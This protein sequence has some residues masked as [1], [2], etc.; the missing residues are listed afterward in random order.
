TGALSASLV[1]DP[2]AGGGAIAV[3]ANVNEVL[4]NVANRALGRP[5]GAYAPVHPAGS[6]GASQSTADVVHTAA[7]LAVL[8]EAD[9]L[10]AAVARLAAALAE[11]GERFGAAP[12]LARTCL[13]DGLAVEARL[14]VDGAAAAVARRRAT[15][16]RSLSPLHAVVLG[17]TVVGDGTGAPPA[18]RAAVVDLLAERCARPLVAAEVPASSLQHGDDLVEVASALAQL[19]IVVAKV[20]RDLRLLSSGPVG[21]FGEVGLPAAMEGSA[22][23]VG[24]VNPAVPETVVQAAIQ[25]DGLER[26]ARSAAAQAELH[27]H[28]YDLATAVAV[29]DQLAVLR[30]A[31]AHL[32]DDALGGLVLHARRSAELATAAR[33]TKVGP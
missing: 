9:Q 21:G 12:A 3:H 25:V 23:F 20:A 7:R 19:S 17:A 13:Q 30:R 32:V 28:P 22:F 31:I 16:A 1:A 14:L 2:L 11:V 27:L 10:D 29:L 15:L 18:Y 6:V 8:D 26:T 4:A 33:P 5:L 24:K